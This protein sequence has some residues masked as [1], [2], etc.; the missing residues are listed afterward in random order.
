M[1]IDPRRT[2]SRPLVS[3]FNLSFFGA[4]SFSLFSGLFFFAL[5]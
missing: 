4:G 2:G 5:P 3:H 1:R